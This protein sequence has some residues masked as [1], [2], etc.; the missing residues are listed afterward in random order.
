MAVMLRNTLLTERLNKM[1][2]VQ[3]KPGPAKVPF[4]EGL[5]ADIDKQNQSVCGW[6]SLSGLP[7]GS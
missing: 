5:M 1:G 6:G 3:R 7:E 2:P 4:P